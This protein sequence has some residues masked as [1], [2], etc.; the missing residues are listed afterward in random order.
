MANDLTNPVFEQ[1]EQRLLLSVTIFAEGFEGIFPGVNWTVNTSQSRLWDDVDYKSH[2]GTQSA[3]C[4]QYNND[5]DSNTYVNDMNSWM[6][7][8]VDLTSYE[9]A[10]LE[11]WH[12]MHTESGYDGLRINVNGSTEW[13][14]TGGAIA[15]AQETVNLDAYAGQSGVEIEFNFFSDGS[16][17]ESGDAG[18]WVDDIN[19]S[20]EVR[21]DE[22]NYEQ[23]DIRSSATDPLSNG[24]Y[25]EGRRLST[26]NDSGVQADEDWYMINVLSGSERVTVSL[27]F[28][29]AQGNINL[30]LVDQSGSVLQTSATTTDN[31]HVAVVVPS[32]GIYYLRVYGANAGN[33]YDLRWNN[34]S[35]DGEDWTVMVYLNGD[36]NLAAEAEGD[37]NEMEMV[38][39]AGSINVVVLVDYDG[40]GDSYRGEITHDSDPYNVNSPLSSMGELDMGNSQTLTDFVTWGAANY[41]ASNYALILWDHGA[42]FAGFGSPE[43][44]E[45]Y[46]IR[47][48][49][50]AAPVAFDLIGFDACLMGMAEI[51]YE[52]KDLNQT[53]VSSEALV[54]AEGWPYDTFLGALNDDPTMTSA[55]LGA[56]AV[57][58]YAQ[59]WVD[60]GETTVSAMDSTYIDA[61]AAAIDAFASTVLGTATEADWTAL[62]SARNAAT[63]YEDDYYYLEADYRDL[64]EFMASVTTGSAAVAIRNAAQNVVDAFDDAVIANWTGSWVGGEGLTI[65][66]PIFGSSLDSEYDNNL[67]FV[68]ETQWD[69][70][71][72]NSTGGSGEEDDAYEE[73]DTQ[74]DAADPQTNGGNWEQTWLSSID[75]PGVQ[76]DDDWYLINVSA[77]SERIVVDLTFAHI[78]GDI[79]LELI[80]SSGAVVEYSD[81]TTDDESIDVAIVSA[82]T[83]YIRV[84]YDDAGN[85]YDLWWDDIASSSSDTTAPTAALNISDITTASS[86]PHAF[87]ITYTDNVAINVSELDNNDIRVTGP[88]SFDELATFVSVNQSTNGKMRIAT[89]EIA[90]PGGSWDITDS[91]TYRVWMQRDEVNDTSGNGVREGSLGTFEVN[92]VQLADFDASGAVDAG[93]IDILVAEVAAGTNNPDC[94]LNGDGLVTDDDTDVLVCDILATQYGD[95]NLDGRVAIEDLSKLAMN[96]NTYRDMGWADGDFTGDGGVTLEDLSVL[97]NY[98]HFEETVAAESTGVASDAEIATDQPTSKSVV[99]TAPAEVSVDL[100]PAPMKI[101]AARGE[102]ASAQ[103]NPPRVASAT[104][105]VAKAASRAKAE[106]SKELDSLSTPDLDPMST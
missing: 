7:R 104:V 45:I 102:T 61:L 77:G 55:E 29:N 56:W 32:A 54:P 39:Y 49:L 50:E 67:A 88:N 28:S 38:D 44:M 66:I 80:D 57:S 18:A 17:I 106:N 103:P 46:E 94:D 92:I 71:L 52:L 87:T 99:V 22:D 86:Q 69:E 25:W 64:R 47:T 60:D 43:E 5:N 35:P 11:F 96:W 14:E 105:R 1:L 42:G 6:R 63:A 21:R 74:A 75:G 27:T 51:A 19:L 81:T 16:V 40:S 36:N 100:S 30:Q 84:H 12:W 13:E 41:P 91:G 101:S 85:A 95:A 82:G 20:G 2:S 90:G 83:Y 24:G 93:D 3:F 58:A 65:Y 59:R 68:N 8:V 37:I 31:E 9:S 89:Y 10:D 33:S 72:N 53:F 98:W 15:W 48:A 26:I 76:A 73:N 4:A 70:F 79:D 23:N 34:S 78:D 62:S 97:A